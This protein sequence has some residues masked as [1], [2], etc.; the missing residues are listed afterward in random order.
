MLTT[1]QLIKLQDAA[2]AAV[3]CEQETQVPCELTIAQW[4]LESGWGEHAPGNN[5]FGIKEVPGLGSQLL[6]TKEVFT[7]EDVTDWLH[8]KEGRTAV[9]ISLPDPQGKRTYEC[10]DLFAVFPNLSHCFSYRAIHLLSRGVYSNLLGT[11]KINKDLISYIKG[12]SV[13]YA[14]DV[15]YYSKIQSLISM[16]EV[17]DALI[18]ARRL[19]QR[20][21]GE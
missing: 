20:E 12:V 19:R 21:G 3:Q 9:A 6:I 17:R 13:I 15:N 10:R 8:R 16:P 5:C 7:L 11:Y 4:A 14:T 2:M 1:Q 18:E